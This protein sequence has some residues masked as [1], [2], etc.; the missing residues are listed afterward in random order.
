MRLP[1]QPAPSSPVRAATALGPAPPVM[2][3]VNLVEPRAHPSGREAISGRSAYECATEPATSNSLAPARA[4]GAPGAEGRAGLGPAG[5]G[6]VRPILGAMGRTYDSIDERLAAWL[7]AQPVFFVA[8]APLGAHGHV[9]CSPKG[10][11]GSLA[12]LGGRQVAYQDLTGSGAETVAHV[13]ENGRIVLMFCAFDG[14]P[15]I[16]RLHGRGEAVMAGDPR[17]GELS[18][19]FPDRLGARAVMLVDIDRFRLRAAT[20]SPSCAS[21]ATAMKWSAGRRQKV[22]KAWR[23]TAGKRTL[24]ASTGCQ[25]SRSLPLPERKPVPPAPGPPAHGRSRLGLAPPYAGYKRGR[26]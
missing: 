5:A 4:C 6:R 9:N 13:P 23:P 3:L 1:G 21:R 2:K 8:T 19:H 11:P 20:A 16:V 12:V 22:P 7:L 24:K 26:P 17:W 18:A 14:P 15:K 25:P 10:G